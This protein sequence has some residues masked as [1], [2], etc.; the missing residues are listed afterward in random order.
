MRRSTPAI[1]ILIVVA[2]IVAAIL[3]GWVLPGDSS[4]TSTSEGDFDFF[5]WWKL[6]SAL[7]I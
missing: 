7:L 3:L 6:V 2:I 4:D 5:P 1:A